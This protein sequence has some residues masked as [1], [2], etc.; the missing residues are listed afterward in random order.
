MTENPGTGNGSGAL[1][2]NVTKAGRFRSGVG[3]G[4][5]SAPDAGVRTPHGGKT[6]SQRRPEVTDMYRED[7]FGAKAFLELLAALIAAAV[8][9][10]SFLGGGRT[11]IAAAWLAVAG[12]N[13]ARALC[14]L[15]RVR[16]AGTSD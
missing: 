7:R 6:A 1:G 11:A 4:S 9:A 12:I 3:F 5:R 13:V 8:S 15:Y 2:W 10:V 16:R 14:D